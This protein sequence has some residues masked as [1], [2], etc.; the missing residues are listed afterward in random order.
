MVRNYFN[1]NPFLF[2]NM[3]TNLFVFVCFLFGCW[4][5]GGVDSELD[6]VDVE[7]A[8]T[9]QSLKEFHCRF[10][11]GVDPAAVEDEFGG[12]IICFTFSLILSNCLN[13]F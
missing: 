10:A 6:L 12:V 3:L 13:G 4:R 7:V 11:V 9:L 2:L 8:V 1:A 5:M